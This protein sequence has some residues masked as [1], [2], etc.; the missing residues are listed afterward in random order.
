MLKNKN[1]GF[2][3][4]GSFYVIRK[5]IPK[6]KKLVKLGANVIP[7]MSFN[8][9]KLNT[10]FGKEFINEIEEITSKKIIYSI[11]ETEKIG[12]EHL[13]DIIV[14]APCSGNTLAKLA[15]GISDTPATVAVKSHLR[16]EN[17]VVIAVSATDAL[18]GNATNIGTLLN[19]KN[20]YFVPFRQDNPI[21]KPRSLSFDVEY[22]IPTIEYAM[23]SEQIQP[24]L[25]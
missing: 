4:T 11:E 14:V 8:L 17:N 24:I 19:R 7:I 3:L 15:N 12:R 9:Y 16:N 6:I 21:T 22:L 20:F 23:V 18:G 13:T 5:V 2:V 25:L 10:K 1:I